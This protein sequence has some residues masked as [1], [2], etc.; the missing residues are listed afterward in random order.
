MIKEEKASCTEKS[1][2]SNQIYAPGLLDFC[3]FISGSPIRPQQMI[4]VRFSTDNSQKFPVAETCFVW[5]VPKDYDVIVV[6]ACAVGFCSE[7]K[8]LISCSEPP[9]LFLN[10]FFCHGVNKT[11]RAIIRANIW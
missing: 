1:P 5:L 8:V 4:R 9:C 3:K 2:Q 10:L 11:F 6:R 7:H